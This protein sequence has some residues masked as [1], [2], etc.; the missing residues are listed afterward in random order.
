MTQFLFSENCHPHLSF[1]PNSTR[2]KR[3]NSPWPSLGSHRHLLQQPNITSN[4]RPSRR[5]V[6]QSIPP[7]GPQPLH[8]SSQILTSMLVLPAEMLITTCIN[9][10]EQ[11]LFGISTFNWV[12]TFLM[13]AWIFKPH[14][15]QRP[16][17]QSQIGTK[18]S[19]TRITSTGCIT[20]LS[21]MYS[22]IAPPIQSDPSYKPKNQIFSLLQISNLRKRNF[23][24]SGPWHYIP[25]QINRQLGLDRGMRQEE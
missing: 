5:L 23:H 8:F 1:Y 4:H 11:T 19:G 22:I 12:T 7:C 25:R 24:Q 17:K 9:L 6:Q 20:F 21:M 10:L 15:N 13:I 14:G 18:L 16:R 2:T 3:A